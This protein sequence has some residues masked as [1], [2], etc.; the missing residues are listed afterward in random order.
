MEL[1]LTNKQL[2]FIIF[3]CW[4][5][6]GNDFFELKTQIKQLVTSNSLPDYVQTVTF[7]IPEFV[8]VYTLIGQHPNAYT[9]R[10]AREIKETAITQF[11]AETNSDYQSL[12]LEMSILQ[13]KADNVE[14]NM[15]TAGLAKALN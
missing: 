5:G 12:L 8:F 2:G 3:I 14:N 4:D 15:C 6:L 10:M 7:T 11:Q 1:Q 13:T 9:A